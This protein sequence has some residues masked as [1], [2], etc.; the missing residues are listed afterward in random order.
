MDNFELYTLSRLL[1]PKLA[2]FLWSDI[3]YENKDTILSNNQCNLILQ[4]LAHPERCMRELG[5]KSNLKKST[6]TGIVKSLEQQ[7]IITRLNPK[8]DKRITILLLTEKGQL[9]GTELREKYRTQF[10]NKIMKLND[11]DQSKLKLC[12][13]DL[14]IILD[15]LKDQKNA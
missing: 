5:R 9:I 6:M 7:N 4:M 3:T 10:I 11:T 15:E 2:N 8:E 12:I 1:I 14:N 13:K